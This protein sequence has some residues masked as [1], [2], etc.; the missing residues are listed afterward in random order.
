MAKKAKTNRGAAKRFKANSA[1]TLIKRRRS[2]RS[3]I[4]SKRASNQKRRLRTTNLVV[5]AAKVF[6]VFKLLRKKIVSAKSR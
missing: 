3:H 6:G 5:N 1:G 4:L 2:N